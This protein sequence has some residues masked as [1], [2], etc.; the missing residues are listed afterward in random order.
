MDQSEPRAAAK[1]HSTW[2]IAVSL[3]TASAL[4]VAI[5]PGVQNHEGRVP[6]AQITQ[7]EA[8][9]RALGAQIADIKD[10]E[11]P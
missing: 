4:G 9:L 7:T 3:I 5:L 11:Q 8:Q 6:T 10:H 1:R 2:M